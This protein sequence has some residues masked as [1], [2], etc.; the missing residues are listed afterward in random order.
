[1]SKSGSTDS[2]IVSHIVYRVPRRNHDAMLRI[3]NEAYVMFKQHG[4]LHYDAFKLSNTDMPME[5]FANMP[6]LFLP[7]KK[8]K[9]GLSQ[10]IIEIAST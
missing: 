3:C 8:M 1:V 5:G 6:V 4:I 2:S 10:F 9:C 7:I